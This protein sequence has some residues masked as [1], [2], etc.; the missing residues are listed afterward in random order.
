MPRLLDPTN[1]NASPEGLMLQRQAADAVCPRPAPCIE[2]AALS[3]ED[4]P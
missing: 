4:R 2:R 3:P 1:P